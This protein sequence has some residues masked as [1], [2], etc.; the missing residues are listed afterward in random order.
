ML[1]RMRTVFLTTGGAA[2]LLAVA[3]LVYVGGTDVLARSQAPPA[4]PV[5][6]AAPPGAPP[7]SF[8]GV[9]DAVKP[10]VVNVA[11]LQPVAGA[12][13]RGLNPFR[14]YAERYF[15]EGAPPVEPSQSLGSGVIVD[16]EGYVLT[17]NHVIE[18]ARMIMVRLSDEQEYEARVVGRDPAT[19]LALLK[20]N[21]RRALPAAKLG[22]SQALRV[23]DW[24]LAIGSPFGLEQTVTAGI[25]SA[26]G[27]AIGAGPYDEFIQTDAAINP[28]N[29]GGPL[30][31]TRGE[32][33]GIN[34]AIFSQSGG[35]VGIGFAIPINL[36][37]ELIPQFKTRG[38]VSRG[39]LG[40]AIAP[41]TPEVAKRLGRTSREGAVVTELVPNGPAA[42]AGVRSGDLIVAFQGTQVRRAG[43]L[44]R[45]VARAS[46]GSAAELR[47]V[48]DGREQ[49][50]SVRLG[51]LPARP[52][53]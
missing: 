12:S 32:V 26:K 13:P 37:K 33:I 21:A 44:P 9:A 49:V 10:A 6:L 34:S 19:D 15:G 22:D 52:G 43:E 1:R 31:S 17:N 36:A 45:L 40:V 5:A 53:R 30:V 25:V 18:N 38:R 16:P 29:S 46:A 35:S 39:W 41:V 50:I 3:Y 14:E 47:L 8:A 51:E 42:R 4:T 48:R 24:V 20:I 27:R 11:T 28:G 7:D 2:L 23:G